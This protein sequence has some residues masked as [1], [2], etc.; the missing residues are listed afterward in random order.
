MD[1]GVVATSKD[2]DRPKGARAVRSIINLLATTHIIFP[3]VVKST[4]VV[5]MGYVLE[6]NSIFATQPKMTP[7]E[8]LLGV[9]ERGTTVT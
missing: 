1:A 7:F 5:T 4:D 9:H 2:C 3:G 8:W 6:R